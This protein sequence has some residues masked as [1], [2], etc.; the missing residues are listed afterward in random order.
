MVQ[1][2]GELLLAGVSLTAISLWFT[3]L[4]HKRMI[5]DLN[6]DLNAEDKP[7]QSNSK[8]EALLHERSI[9][10]DIVRNTRFYSDERDDARKRLAQITNEIGNLQ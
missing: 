9:V 2:I 7:K 6:T 8:L 1:I 5:D 10:E 3:N 4:I